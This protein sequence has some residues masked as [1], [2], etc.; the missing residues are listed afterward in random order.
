MDNKKIMQIIA[1]CAIPG[2]A[3]ALGMYYLMTKC[4]HQYTWPRKGELDGNTIKYVV[5]V[6]CGGEFLFND[7]TLKV[8]EKI[9]HHTRRITSVRTAGMGR[10]VSEAEER[11]P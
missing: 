10:L 2:G 6:K 8:G 11:R 3:V 4:W 5:C 7:D 9:D 1:A